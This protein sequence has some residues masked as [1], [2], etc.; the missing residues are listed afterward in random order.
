MGNILGRPQIFYISYATPPPAYSES[1]ELGDDYSS[2]YDSYDDSYAPYGWAQF[3]PDLCCYPWTSDYEG[4]DDS[5]WDGAVVGVVRR[6]GCRNRNHWALAFRA[7][8]DI[9]QLPHRI[10]GFR[11][12][13]PSRCKRTCGDWRRVYV[14]TEISSSDDDSSS[15]ATQIYIIEDD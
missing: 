11:T 4:Y 8:I 15:Q 6:K 7:G 13:I 5:A 9:S 12:R 10:R 14:L 1:D 3:I 2:T